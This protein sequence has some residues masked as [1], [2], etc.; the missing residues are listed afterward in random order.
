[1]S[2]LDKKNKVTSKIAS[3]K[4][5]IADKTDKFN[6][7]KT[8]TL[9][10]FNNAKGKVV[11]FLT[12]LLTILVGFKLL[13]DTIVDTFTYYLS[14]IEKEIKSGIYNLVAPIHPLRSEVH[15]QNSMDFGFELGSFSGMTNRVVSSRKL[16][17]ELNYSF[18]HPNPLEFW[19]K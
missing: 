7:K 19:S 10:S 8:E 13:I 1:M 16:I 14:K 17:K 2:T 3:T 5:M 6:K 9:E 12:D 4:V 15:K 18:L 11:A